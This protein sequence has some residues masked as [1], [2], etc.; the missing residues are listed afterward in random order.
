[1]VAHIG[2][3]VARGLH[4]AHRL[5]EKDGGRPIGLVHRD[6]TP[7]NVLLSYEGAVK[8]TDFGIA[9][10]GDRFTTPGV[11][12][13]KFAYMSPE[14]ARGEDV[15]PRTDVFALGI[16]LWEMLTGGRLFVGD[17]D[18]ATLRAVQH[19]EI[20][21]PARLN[22]D[23]P[24]ELDAV[25]MR[26]LERERDRRHQTAEELERALRQCV[27][28]HARSVDETDVG[29][30]LRHR[31]A[32][33]LPAG[34]VDSAAEPST[35]QPASAPTASVPSANSRGSSEPGMSPV[36]A[37]ETAADRR[38][39]A[40][41]AL[42]ASRAPEVMPPLSGKATVRPP[43]APRVLP[44]RATVPLRAPEAVLALPGKA[45]VPVRVPRHTP[46]SPSAPAPA[47]QATSSQ[48]TLR[49]RMGLFAGAGAAVL[50]V[51]ALPF[52]IQK[53]SG[54]PR[55]SDAAAPRPSASA[56]SPAAPPSAVL[57]PSVSPEPAAKAGD[58]EAPA[59]TQGT[60]PASASAKEV[61]S[62]TLV[63]NVTPWA[64][65][66]IDGQ[67]KGEVVG[68]RQW[69][70]PSGTHE[71]RIVHPKKTHEEEVTLN[72]SA[73]ALVRFDAFAE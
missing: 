2:S 46:A 38:G 73:R 56:P 13:G 50:L 49:R 43:E 42:A 36:V 65:V 20:A 3:E 5:K 9:K 63:V 11:L 39:S 32:A 10:V 47:L 14:Q 24:P 33:E 26:A 40:A 12:K 58:R 34:G 44:G 27:L 71:L 64:D 54:A 72:G 31:F 6:V 25:V 60:P 62:A 18:V 68:K 15:D 22:P 1:M 67:H 57:P 30:F 8:L 17:S 4:Y 69:A 61:P 35:A 37:V 66:F 55:S 45:T 23:V 53:P 41:T 28:R 51:G 48:P 16:V 59:R 52:A 19:S 21:P 7:H 29:R 70:L